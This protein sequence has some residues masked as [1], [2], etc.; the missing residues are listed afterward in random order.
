M[1][2][3]VFGP[4]SLQLNDKLAVAAASGEAMNLEACFSQLTLD[5]IGKAVFN[6]DFDSLNVNSPLIQVR[7]THTLFGARDVGAR[8]HMCVHAHAANRGTVSG[9]AGARHMSSRCIIW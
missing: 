7:G 9:S 5:I 8:A 4:S 6:Y 3:R 1:L 2:T